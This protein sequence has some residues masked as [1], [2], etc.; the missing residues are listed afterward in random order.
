MLEYEWIPTPK[1]KNLLL[2][3]KF[4]YSQQHSTNTYYCSRRLAGCRA[5]VKLDKLGNV[6]KVSGEHLHEPP[7][8]MKTASGSYFKV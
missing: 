8:Y 4:T 6:F 3:N 2:L 5:T 7:R 1:G